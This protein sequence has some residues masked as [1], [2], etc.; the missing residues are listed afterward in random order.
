MDSAGI[1]VRPLADPLDR[2]GLSHVGKHARLELRFGVRR[3]RTELIH[4]Y[5]EPPFRVGRTFAE[6]DGVHL[7]LASSAPGVFG[8]D[9]LE[10]SIVVEPGARVRLTSQSALQV[11][12]SPHRLDAVLNHHYLVGEGGVLHCEWDPV[13][14]FPGA[15]L[16]QRLAVDLA[17][18]ARLLWSDAVMAGRDARGE[19][20]L[21]HRLD[22]ELAVRRH[23][24]LAYLERYV[25]EPTL[26]G[27]NRP[28]LAGDATYF[29]SVISVGDVAIDLD[30]LQREIGNGDGV[31]GAIDRIETEVALA[32]LM[33]AD[34]PAFHAARARVRSS[35]TPALSSPEPLNP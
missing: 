17:A 26:T 5:A 28:W 2:R 35:L 19:R 34:G 18:S 31:V 14:P 13:I 1:A 30:A 33:A 9:H 6:A 16:R 7:I 20:W 27:V 25:I 15:A 22:H 8:G 11:H 21:F 23:G 32:R 29:G 3:G 10:Q 24:T 12:A 4:V